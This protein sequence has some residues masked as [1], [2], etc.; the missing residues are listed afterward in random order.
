MHP[1]DPGP[2]GLEGAGV[3]TATGPGVTDL[4]PGDRVMG[5]FSAAFATVAHADHRTLVK[6]PD[7]WS[8]TRA[9]AVPVAHMTALHALTEL[10]GIG[11]G[12]PVLI[13]AGAGGVG[14]A[15]VQL[16]RHLGAEVY[17]T[18]SRAK[19]PALRALGIDDDHLAS[20][21]EPGFGTR[22]GA[23]GRRMALVLNSLTGEL[24]DESLRL[25]RPGGLLAE[26]GRTDPRDPA[27]VAAAHPGTRYQAFNLL[28]LPP[29]HLARLLNRVVE[30]F[31]EGA[32]TWPAVTDMDIRRAPEAFTLLR[33]GTHVGKVVLT[34]PPLLDPDGTVLITGGT[35]AIGRALARH[36]VTEHG[37][38]RLLLAGRRGPD[39][40]GAAELASDLNGLGA[41]VR[42]AAVDVADRDA[43]AAMIETVPGR[44]PLTAVI[45]AA[46]V[47]DDAPVT[48]LTPGQIDRVMRVKADGAWHLHELTARHPLTAFVLVSSVM[49]TLGGAGQGG[50]TA[51][52]AFLDALAHH[53]RAQGLPALALAWGLWDDA[54]GM[55]GALTDADRARFAR[56]GLVEMTPGHG[57]ALLEAALPSPHPVLA[58]A[59]LDRDV[60]RD[61]GGDLPPV[62]RGVV[63]A[64]AA[65]RPGNVPGH[66][67]PLREGL[68]GL[69]AGERAGI[70]ADLIRT[71]M[72]AVLGSRPEAIGDDRPF[73]ELGF[74]SLTSVE[75]RN[76]LNR[77]TG[78]K[79]PLTLLFEAP[80]LA[81]LVAVL[82]T[83]LV[84]PE[85]TPAAPPV[86]AGA[87]GDT[88][89][90]VT[91]LVEAATAEELLDFIDR[92]LSGP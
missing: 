50:Y 73:G 10:A 33:Q 44:H 30:L 2:L 85:D 12:D 36:L 90:D 82:D 41:E 63:A 76:R 60:L 19:W 29:E 17:A 18:A 3:V 91:A 72:A 25:L 38:R 59:R 49:G 21:R 80:T 87:P 58:P 71:H 62:F 81:E 45:H 24:L 43:V 26:L 5:L 83:G 57:L 68:T 22:F 16:A 54:D 32:F 20:S 88:G 14:M 8:Y 53:R 69:G 75:F 77:A 37:A 78:L 89:S 61:L 4:A 39:A 51:A 92:E 27:E 86:L 55:I 42:F 65:S 1:A 64:A 79:L 56:A 66:R 13:H 11:A 67:R 7:G 84:P 74:D 46:G 31:A 23:A 47:V 34:V 15:A 40:P 28:Q 6:I 9:A 35:G 48:S 52:N 70:L